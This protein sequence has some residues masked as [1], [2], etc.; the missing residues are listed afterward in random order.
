MLGYQ[1][2]HCL[3]SMTKSAVATTAFKPGAKATK[4]LDFICRSTLLNTLFLC[5]LPSTS[6]NMSIT[7][8]LS[9]AN[10]LKII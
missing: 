3:L 10:A 7:Q 8:K 4:V 2:Q 9:T 5:D 1:N 6:P